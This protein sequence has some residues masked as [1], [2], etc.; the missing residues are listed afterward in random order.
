M[1]EHFLRVSRTSLSSSDYYISRC[2]NEHIKL[3]RLSMISVITIWIAHGW[4]NVLMQIAHSDNTTDK[5]ANIPT[6]YVL[7]SA[8]KRQP[9]A[10]VGCLEYLPFPCVELVFLDDMFAS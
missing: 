2:C 7:Q 4:F 8:N 5:G 9:H 6:R 3:C 1:C 10:P